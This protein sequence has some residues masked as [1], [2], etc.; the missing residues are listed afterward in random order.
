MELHVCL[1]LRASIKTKMVPK[2][3]A[4]HVLGDGFS[5]T[6]GKHSAIGPELHMLPLLATALRSKYRKV[7]ALTMLLLLVSRLVR[8]GS[9]AWR[10]GVRVHRVRPANGVLGVNT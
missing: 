5:P 7:H 10:I 3:S 9:T 4:N 6:S 2:S 1:A 8:L